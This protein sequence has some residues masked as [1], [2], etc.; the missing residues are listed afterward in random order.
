MISNRYDQM[1]VCGFSRNWCV[2]AIFETT[3]VSIFIGF[4]SGL[5]MGGR[6]SSATFTIATMF[7]SFM[8]LLLILHLFIHL[9]LVILFM[10]GY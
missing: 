1:I 4:G 9:L 3:I 6:T 10:F 5:T 7:L 2:S 8:P